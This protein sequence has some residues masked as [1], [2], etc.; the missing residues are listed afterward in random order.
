[1]NEEEIVNRFEEIRN[2]LKMYREQL[3]SFKEDL[4]IDGP[5]GQY[6]VEVLFDRDAAAI[7]RQNV[8]VS[9]A[10]KLPILNANLSVLD[11]GGLASWPLRSRRCR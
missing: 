10:A 9:D 4:K 11:R 6:H 1:M 2:E 3:D 8:I 5:S 7:G